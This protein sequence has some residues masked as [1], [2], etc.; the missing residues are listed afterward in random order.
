MWI[1]L[2]R[3][4]MYGK[5]DKFFLKKYPHGNGRLRVGDVVNV[6]PYADDN[7]VILS[8]SKT[9]FIAVIVECDIRW[10]D[11]QKKELCTHVQGGY[12]AVINDYLFSRLEKIDADQLALS[13]GFVEWFKALFR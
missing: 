10:V 11:G 6:R 1:G 5:T 13:I 4:Y 3:S 2:K 7:G 9:N 8:E 12:S